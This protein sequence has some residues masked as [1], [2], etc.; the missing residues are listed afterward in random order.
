MEFFKSNG[1]FDNL[2]PD[3]LKTFFILKMSKNKAHTRNENLLNT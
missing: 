3:L 2:Y 1:F